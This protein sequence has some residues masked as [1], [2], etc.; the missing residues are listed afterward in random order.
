MTQEFC[1]E[2]N[3][4]LY[5]KEDKEEKQLF[6][7]CKTCEHFEEAK[8]NTTY[9]IYTDRGRISSSIL[10][11]DIVSDPTLPRVRVQCPKCR[12]TEAVSYYGDEADEEVAF[13]MHYVCSKCSHVWVLS[14]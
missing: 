3:N 14:D 12:H 11:A 10:P 4:I 1:R 13:V 8:S 2:C 5:P 9:C 7:A 6:M